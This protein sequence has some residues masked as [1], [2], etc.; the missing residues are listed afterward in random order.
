MG[1]LPSSRGDL[2]LPGA[3]NRA[4]R[5]GFPHRAGHAA[6]CTRPKGEYIDEMASLEKACYGEIDA[7]GVNHTDG[8]EDEIHL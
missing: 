3:M 7:Q 2:L 1:G 4:P 5:A 6:A 8:E